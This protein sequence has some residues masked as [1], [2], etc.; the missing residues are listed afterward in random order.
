LYDGKIRQLGKSRQQPASS[1]SVG[2]RGRVSALLD[3]VT[4][5]SQPEF[6]DETTDEGVF[7]ADLC[8]PLIREAANEVVKEL[9]DSAPV[10]R[11]AHYGDQRLVPCVLHR[12]VWSIS[13]DALIRK[14]TGVPPLRAKEEWRAFRGNP[15]GEARI[16]LIKEIPKLD[17]NV[18]RYN[19]LMLL[20]SGECVA[21]YP[22]LA[23][24]AIQFLAHL[25]QMSKYCR[26]F[27]F[28]TG[29]DHC[30]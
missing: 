30:F 22:E 21:N 20:E 13:A 15:I 16:A 27:A 9:L 29:F 14:R 10:L 1:G 19:K 3:L 2:S 26:R 4:D 12:K 23:A 6:S 28:V 11:F 24:C 5:A 17:R 25:P 7:L 18:R 8:P